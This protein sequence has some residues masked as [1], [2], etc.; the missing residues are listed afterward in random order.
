MTHKSAQARAAYFRDYVKNRDAESLRQRVEALER[1]L[2]QIKQGACFMTA[3]QI[4]T[5]ARD[6]LTKEG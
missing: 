2:R 1:T 4:E 5:M 3:H 6:A